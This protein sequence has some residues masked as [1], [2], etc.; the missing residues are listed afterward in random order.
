MSELTLPS[1]S[2]RA[3]LL[4][5]LLAS[6]YPLLGLKRAFSIIG[7]GLALY[8]IVLLIRRGR[9]IFE[10]PAIRAALLVAAG[11]A[12]P[13]LLSLTDAAFLGVSFAATGR[14][15][16]YLPILIAVIVLVQEQQITR[17][18]LL[19]SV[20]VTVL[21]VVDGLVQLAWGQ[22]IFGMPYNDYRIGAYWQNQMKFGYYM[23]FYGLFAVA[24]F[25]VCRP[26]RPLLLTGF[27]LVIAIGV[28]ISGNR[29]AWLMFFSFSGILFWV[30][31]ASLSRHR[32]LLLMGGFVLVALLAVGAYE[33]NF[34]VR[35]RIEQSVAGLQWSYEAIDKAS[36]FRLE[37]WRIAVDLIQAHPINGQGLDSYQTQ[38]P[39][40]AQHPFWV[41]Q[42]MTEGPYPH[43]YLLE[44]GTATGVIGWLGLI[45][46]AVVVGRAWRQASLEQ[47]A[48]AWP[49]LI[50]LMALWFPLNTHRSFY[51][52]EL[53][54]GNLLMM[55]LILGNLLPAQRPEQ[56]ARKP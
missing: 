7:I 46:I 55:G 39:S 2:R 17:P 25:A 51:S 54:M 28:L 48:M 4:G 33:L 31:V 32:W 47:R 44:I 40:L 23:G 1:S 22:D 53:I 13:L 12:L 8:G 9:I 45:A 5:G 34:T 37:L 11:F 16:L 49:A 21:W 20:A 30:H 3:W 29:E 18:M 43:Q 42:H 27:W 14:S 15:L 36:A 41:N 35:D 56:V 24:A 26:A 10:N 52:S 50:Y 38:F 19:L 6:F